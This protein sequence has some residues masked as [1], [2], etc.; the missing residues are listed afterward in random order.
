MELVTAHKLSQNIDVC[1]HSIDFTLGTIHYDNLIDNDDL[2]S[3]LN[4]LQLSVFVTRVECHGWENPSLEDLTLYLEIRSINK[5]V[6]DL[7]VSNDIIDLEKG[8]FCPRLIEH[9][10]FFILC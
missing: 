3:L 10:Y 2:V 4:A 1:P 5:S 7:D 6:I 8:V 9:F